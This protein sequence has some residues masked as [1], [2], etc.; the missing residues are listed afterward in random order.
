MK[1]QA[2]LTPGH[3]RD[4]RPQDEQR[5]PEHRTCPPSEDAVIAAFKQGVAV[6][7]IARRAG[8]TPRSIQWMLRKAGL[9]PDPHKRPSATEPGDATV[10]DQATSFR[11][12]DIAF[13]RA[14]VRAIASGDESPPMIGVHKDR[15]PLNARIV[16]EPVP[17]SSGCTSP[18]GECADLVPPVAQ[19]ARMVRGEAPTTE[20]SREA[21]MG[22]AETRCTDRILQA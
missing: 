19:L 2:M 15:R 17:H 9:R 11:D 13:Q 8:R 1:P 5:N 20:P 7:A 4:E 14:M 10:Q 6:A 18:A 3:R 16:F 21:E 12:Q 22:D